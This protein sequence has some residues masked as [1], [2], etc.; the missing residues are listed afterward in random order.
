[1]EWY[2]LYAYR[3]DTGSRHILGIVNSPFKPSDR[4]PYTLNRPMHAKWIKA[5]DADIE[6][7]MCSIKF[8]INRE[9]I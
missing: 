4:F 8:R 5:I 9:I 1:M 3:T 7:S 2:M 6:S